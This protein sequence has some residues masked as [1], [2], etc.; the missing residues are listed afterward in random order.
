MTQSSVSSDN[1]IKKDQSCSVGFQIF[2]PFMIAGMGTIG[3]GIVLGNVEVGSGEKKK[4]LN[5]TKRNKTI[6]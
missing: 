6:I 2:I 5:F 4:I 3:A 1:T